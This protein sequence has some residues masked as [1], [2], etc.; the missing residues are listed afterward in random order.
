MDKKFVNH[1]IK[2][3]L[4]VA[5]QVFYSVIVIIIIIITITTTTTTTS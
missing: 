5:I 2:I 3:T 1:M 4:C